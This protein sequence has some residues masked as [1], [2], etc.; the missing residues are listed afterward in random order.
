[1]SKKTNIKEEGY[2]TAFKA[3]SLFGGVQLITIFITVLKSKVIAL[4]LGAAG[5]GIMSLFASAIQLVYS[6]SNLGLAS[7]GVRDIAQ[8]NNQGNKEQLS[9]TVL[10]IIR[11]IVATGILGTLVT[12]VLSPWLS[13][14]FF[15]SNKFTFSF[16]I[17]SCMVLFLS[18]NDGFNSVLQGTRNLA[19]LAKA[20]IYGSII[21]FI[22]SVPLFILFGENGIVP[23]MI[24]PAIFSSIITY[25][26]VRKIKLITVKQTISES[27]S[28]GSTTVKLGLMMA[29]TAIVVTMIE[30][31]L[32][33]YISKNGGIADV[34]LYQAGWTLNAG[35]LGLVFTAM[36]KDYFPRLSENS[37]NHGV[38]SK[39]INQQA[40]I[41]I[42]ILSP[43]IVVMIVFL[44]F[45]IQL[46]YTKEFLTIVPMTRWLL[47]GS[48]I[49][50]GS[51]AISFVFLAKG[52]GKTFLFN[53][54]GI[55]C[56]TLPSYL[57]GYHFFGIQGI[58][59]AY[60]F[61]YSVYFIWVAI[62]AAKKY[63]IKYSGTFWKLFTLMLTALLVF[64]LGEV[65]WS[66]KYI[67]GGMLILTIGIYCIYELNNRMNLV[68]L[69]KIKK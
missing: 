23:A 43:M 60:I 20:N 3:T 18:I 58:G 13:Q 45:L 31:V 46:I 67:T 5:Y 55:N 41:A 64:P 15:S 11:W 39:K 53:E 7:S 52:D 61:N 27:I 8:A 48:L 36:A 4:F 69:F 2:K 29:I 34:G 66:A 9:K 25:F 6:F 44:P 63:D 65:I 28:L 1:M 42:L 38:L 57:L 16:I 59:F 32:K 10:A 40:E 49:K 47:I 26:F 68:S 51:W 54:I 30:F 37:N 50:S 35:Y 19:S 56:I 17:L 14:W 22:S 21:G 12:V 33:T 62:V 24:L